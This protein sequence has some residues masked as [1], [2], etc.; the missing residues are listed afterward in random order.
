MWGSAFDSTGTS[1][2][3]RAGLATICASSAITVWGGEIPA[4]EAESVGMSTEGLKRDFETAIR[5]AIID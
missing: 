4:A 1:M 2:C 3:L 5:Q